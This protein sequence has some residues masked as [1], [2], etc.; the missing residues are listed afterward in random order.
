MNAKTKFYYFL[1]LLVLAVA[2][3]ALQGIYLPQESG[4]VEIQEFIIEKGQGSSE[5]SSNLAE[6]GLI[7]SKFLFDSLAVV[8]GEHNTL[9]AGTYDL[10]RGMNA[11]EILDKLSS[12]DVA[13]E[14][15]TIIEGWDLRDIAWWFENKGMFQAEEIF[16]V[17][18]LPAVNGLEKEAL[19]MVAKLVND[20][21]FL[22][23]KP[24]A[25][26]LEGYLFPD[27]YHIIKG[28]T[29]EQ[30]IRKMLSNFDKKIGADLRA[31]IVKQDKS[32]FEILIMASLL[33]KEV[34]TLV[35]KKLV[36]GILWKRLV[37][38]WPLQVDASL[39]YIT[40]KASSGITKQDKEND[41]LYNT[42]KYYG[43]PL[44]PISNPGLESI[45]A[46]VYYE[47]NPYWFYLSK[48]D[49]ETVFSKTLQE[50]N[51]NRA[52]YLQ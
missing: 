42:Y 37:Y 9:L 19:A 38:G 46:S 39:T 26:S 20:F 48:P 30:N 1:L 25:V 15:L 12:G 47:S 49:G 31:E 50:H 7:K 6:A 29:V 45:E 28:A 23:E 36:A 11:S 22:G 14:V 52:K 13:K 2:V 4:D 44:G 27:T 8:K 51:I 21:E 16:E 34:Q 43:L 33:E 18:G 17:V 35:D 10:S 5:I 3:W 41:S 24:A 40:G 32:L